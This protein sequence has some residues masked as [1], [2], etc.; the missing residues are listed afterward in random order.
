MRAISEGLGV[1]V[2]WDHPNQYVW[3]GSKD[4]PKI[5]DVIKPVDA[6]PYLKYYPKD[7]SIFTIFSPDPELNGKKKT[8][9]RVARE[10]DF[11]LLIG[12][13]IIVYRIDK[14]VGTDKKDYIR[15]SSNSKGTM[16]NALFLMNSDSS[17]RLQSP[18]TKESVLNS[19]TLEYF[20]VD[21]Y[22]DK[23]TTW[24]KDIEYIGISLTSESLIAVK[25][26][27]R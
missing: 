7:S 25:S 10:S 4:V 5:E 1:N 14:S 16:G 11:P 2:E 19:V 9:I 24:L 20:P 21:Y 8:T 27:W 18:Y 17:P 26:D 3:I 13:G 22:A 12:N 15:F 23:D 6:K